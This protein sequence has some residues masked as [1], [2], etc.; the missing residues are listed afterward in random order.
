MLQILMLQRLS[1]L[2]KTSPI[3][4]FPKEISISRTKNRYILYIAKSPLS[5]PVILFTE[6]YTATN[7]LWGTSMFT[8]SKLVV[9]KNCQFWSTKVSHH[10]DLDL[11]LFVRLHFFNLSNTWTS[12]CNLSIH[13]YSPVYLVGLTTFFFFFKLI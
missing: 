8:L 6:L 2:H 1:F 7:K 9:I 10:L 13:F 4:N 5:Y 11:W 3:L 12:S